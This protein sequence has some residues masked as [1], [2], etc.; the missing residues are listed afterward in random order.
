MS[1]EVDCPNCDGTGR[2]E[3]F[4]GNSCGRRTEDCCGGCYV[5]VD[6]NECNGHGVI[7][8]DEEE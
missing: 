3:Q 8:E 1:K 7:H 2:V 6:C 4:A 5:D